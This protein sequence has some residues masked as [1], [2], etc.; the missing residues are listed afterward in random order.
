MALLSLAA[1]AAG[2]P[3]IYNRRDRTDMDAL[4]LISK[5]AREQVSM[6]ESLAADDIKLSLGLS[7]IKYIFDIMC[8]K[9]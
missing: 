5:I 1:L 9:Y 6:Q 7:A 3:T 2:F 4:R 8:P